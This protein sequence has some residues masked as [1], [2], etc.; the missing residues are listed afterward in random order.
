MNLS[1][2]MAILSAFNASTISRLKK[3][4]E[5]VP[6]K[7][8]AIMDH[9]GKIM[10]STRNYAV[11]R[12]LMR[13]ADPPAL[14]FIGF[15]LTDLTFISDG[16]RDTRVTDEGQNVINFDKLMKFHS[17]V[18][19]TFAVRSCSSRLSHA[20]LRKFQEPFNLAPIDELQAYLSQALS[21]VP[22]GATGQDALW[23]RS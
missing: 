19:G 8:K 3:T 17:T 7:N 15:H 4:W 9:L 5:T 11:Y 6:P 2:V 23:R 18:A 21:N 22:M 12:S 13:E 20:A 16:N 14:P 10:A 1:T